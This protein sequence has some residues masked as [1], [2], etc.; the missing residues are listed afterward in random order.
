MNFSGYVSNGIS[1]IKDVP[2]YHMEV[3]GSCITLNTRKVK[4]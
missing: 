2:V 1:I 4:E 3:A